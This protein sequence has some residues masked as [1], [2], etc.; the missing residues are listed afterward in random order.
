M[1]L[2]LVTLLH[3]DI[4]SSGRKVP[5][6]HLLVSRNVNTCIGILFVMTVHCV[7]QVAN[8]LEQC[9]GARMPVKGEAAEYSL[10]VVKHAKD[11]KGL[12][13]QYKYWCL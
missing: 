7:L 6:M 12:S 1:Y 3:Y 11:N 9:N 4:K 8:H 13:W 5:A 10:E 2:A